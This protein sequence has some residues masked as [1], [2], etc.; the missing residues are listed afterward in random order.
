MQ[1]ALLNRRPFFVTFM[2]GD[3]IALDSAFGD[4]APWIEIEVSFSLR[5]LLLNGDRLVLDPSDDEW[6]AAIAR[7]VEAPEDK[8]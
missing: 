4:D 8:R 1:R 2:E 7:G 6:N 3:D 5:E